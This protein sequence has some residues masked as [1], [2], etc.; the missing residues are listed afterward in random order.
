M[1]ALQEGIRFLAGGNL[2]ARTQSAITS[3]PGARQLGL[4]VWQHGL[5]RCSGWGSKLQP[6]HNTAAHTRFRWLTCGRHRDAFLSSTFRASARIRDLEWR[7]TEAL[8]V[9]AEQREPLAVAASLRCSLLAG[10][11]CRKHS[12]HFRSVQS[13]SNQARFPWHGPPH[14]W[15]TEGRWQGQL[16]YTEATCD[17]STTKAAPSHCRLLGL[18][19]M[20]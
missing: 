8:P 3:C 17:E 10:L 4:S 9:G 12:P 18:L 6:E 7:F 1:C 15:D 11:C 5:G 19:L 14:R 13:T 20:P 2:K 16:P